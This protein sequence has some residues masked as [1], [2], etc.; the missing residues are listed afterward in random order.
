MRK[1]VDEDTIEYAN[2]IW[3]LRSTQTPMIEMGFMDFF[4]MG[5]LRQADN[6][7]THCPWDPK[8]MTFS[9]PLGD[10][11]TYSQV[12]F[13]ENM[14]S[15]SLNAMASSTLGEMSFDSAKLNKMFEMFPNLS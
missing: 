3:D 7:H 13:S 1:P 8:Y 12:V 10:E 4:I 2:M 14:V 5:E 11:R 9:D 6:F 15:C